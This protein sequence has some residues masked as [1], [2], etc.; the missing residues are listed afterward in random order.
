[1]SGSKIER[2]YDWVGDNTKVQ[3]F[4]TLFTATSVL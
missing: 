1:M 3:W 4:L 2:K